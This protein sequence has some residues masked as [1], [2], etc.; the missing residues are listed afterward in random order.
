MLVAFAIHSP[1]CYWEGKP[2]EV[3][4]TIVRRGTSLRV[5]RRKAAMRAVAICRSVLPSCRFADELDATS[6]FIAVT[7]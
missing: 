5:E 7:F 3:K 1:A 2:R 6:H 4:H